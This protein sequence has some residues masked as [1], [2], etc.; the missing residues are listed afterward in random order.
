M[1]LTP[2]LGHGAKMAFEDGLELPC[3]CC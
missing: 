2:S 3:S 1:V